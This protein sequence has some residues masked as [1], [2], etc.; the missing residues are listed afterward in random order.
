MD[1]YHILFVQ[2]SPL[3]YLDYF[4]LLAYVNNTTVNIPVQVYV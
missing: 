3:G 1:V 2:S 4:R